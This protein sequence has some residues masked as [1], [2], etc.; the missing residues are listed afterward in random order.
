MF[1][2]AI[3]G[4]VLSMLIPLAETGELTCPTKSVH[5]PAGEV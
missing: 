2:N 3:T 1:A 5:V 4:T